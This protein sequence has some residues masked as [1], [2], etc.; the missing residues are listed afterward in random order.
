MITFQFNNGQTL[1]ADSQ[2]LLLSNLIKTTV[3]DSDEQDDTLVP[4]LQEDITVEVFNDIIKYCEH[5]NESPMETITKP[6]KSSTLKGTVDEWYYKFIDSYT[7]EQLK[8]VVIAANYLDIQ[9]L[10]QLSCAAI[11]CKIKGKPIE[12]IRKILSC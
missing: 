10:F 9:P 3:E 12:D 11:A 7:M 6:L 2:S 8:S 1:Q 5:Y 4:I